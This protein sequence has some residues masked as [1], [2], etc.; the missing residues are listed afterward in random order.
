MKK[1]I[2]LSTLFLL[3]II[4]IDAFVATT[5][6]EDVDNSYPATLIEA[7]KENPDK[8]EELL[9][10]YFTVNPD[11]LMA[12]LLICS[13]YKRRP[14]DYKMFNIQISCEESVA[15]YKKNTMIQ[16]KLIPEILADFE[17]QIEG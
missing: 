9:S 4:R 6:W 10:N 2:L 7:I 14:S 17:S 11:K 13:S 8:R 5:P 12:C 1:S 3:V 16:R 15:I